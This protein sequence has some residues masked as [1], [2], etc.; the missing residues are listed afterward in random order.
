MEEGTSFTVRA[1]LAGGATP[2]RLRSTRLAA[3]FHGVR[4]TTEP[5]D[6]HTRCRA[7]ASKM[8]PD[9][10]FT[11]VTA[12]RLWGMPLPLWVRDDVVH[13]ATAHGTA[14]P[15]GR[16]VNGTQFMPGS[17][18][19]LGLAG[20]HVLS[21]E[22]TWASLASVLGLA[23]LVAAGDF[24]VTPQFA[25]NAAPPASIS[26]LARVAARRRLR[27]RSLADRAAGLV[28]VGPLSR[29]ES[30]TRMLAVTGG[31]P[32]PECNY[33]VSP[34]LM[35]DLG[36]P[37]FRFGLDYHGASHRSARQHAKDVARG[38]LA[39]EHG[40]DA[41]QVGATDLFDAPFDLL[42]RLRSRLIGRGAVVRPLAA[43]NVALAMR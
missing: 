30:L 40:W 27:G 29:P 31:V 14:R 9:A 17:V 13:V 7:Y 4:S 43:R 37:E 33:R 20:L 2:G 12:A 23:D 5:F 6:T 8:R 26:D 34:L 25:S 24:L 11:S 15:G 36:W 3:P 19:S 39:R 10:V 18:R 16:G 22:D 42:A 41:M 35:F 28:R 38:D 1:A 32:E 21:P